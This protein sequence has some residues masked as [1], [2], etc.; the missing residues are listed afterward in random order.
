MRLG[1]EI[2]REVV[3]AEDVAGNVKPTRRELDP[4]LSAQLLARA[5]REIEMLA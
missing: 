4:V 3:W 1:K 2:R 5:S